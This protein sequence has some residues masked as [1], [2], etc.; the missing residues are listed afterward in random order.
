M[1]SPFARFTSPALP[2]G[3]HANQATAAREAG[4][5]IY[6]RPKAVGLALCLTLALSLYV[7]PD[8]TAF[9][10]VDPRNW[11]T[12]AKPPSRRV[13]EPSGGGITSRE[14]RFGRPMADCP[15][16]G[17]DQ[18]SAQTGLG[19]PAE[20]RRSMAFRARG[21]RGLVP[22]ET[23]EGNRLELV[24]LAAVPGRACQSQSLV[25]QA[26]TIRRAIAKDSLTAVER[27]VA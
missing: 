5:H 16:K 11:F 10:Y 26:G 13:G 17:H 24:R 22:A 23:R 6:L 27:E 7:Y 1:K 2:F 8:S 25:A 15:E 3:V 14:N 12:P 21:C 20:N 4:R 19:S 18:A 9:R